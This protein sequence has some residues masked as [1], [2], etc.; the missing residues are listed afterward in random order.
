[1]EIKELIQAGHFT[2]ARQKLVAAVKASPADS[3]SRTLLFQVLCYCGEWEKADRHLDAIAAQDTIRGA[4]SLGYKNAI[5]AELERAAVVSNNRH[6]SF[7]SE[8]PDY[9]EHFMLFRSDVVEGKEGEAAELLAQLVSKRPSLSGTLNGQPFEGF[10]ETDATLFPFLEA[11]THEHY[12]WVPFETI[13]EL[14]VFRPETLLDLLWIGARITTWEGLTMNC[15]LPVLY[16]NSFLHEDAR[17]QMGRMTDWQTL[18]GPYSRGFG[19]HVFDVGGRDVSLLEIEELVFT[20]SGKEQSDE[21][22]S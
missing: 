14:S 17:I 16:P 13:R 3:A 19:Q 22:K 5:R 1:M 11:F 7:I 2:E 21:E 8:P 15:F 9:L 18:A 12:L 6:A 4:G 10:C 20:F